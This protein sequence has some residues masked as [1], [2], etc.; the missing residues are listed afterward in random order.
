MACAETILCGQV[1]G[2]TL[3]ADEAERW[4][5]H[6]LQCPHCSEALRTAAEA[7]VGLDLGG[8]PSSTRAGQR[9]LARRLHG[10]SVRPARR[11]TA[12]L[13]IAAAIA[14]AAGIFI[15]NSSRVQA[16]RAERLI[17]SA[18]GQH[19][20]LAV[21]LAGASYA[22]LAGVLR[23]EVGENA[24]G[25]AEL[26]EA[27]A[28]AAAGLATEPANADWLRAQAEADLLEGRSDAAVAALQRALLARP[29]D[30]A[31]LTDLGAAYYQSG[32][33]GPTTRYGAALDA[34]GQALAARAHDPL[35]RY[36]RALVEEA[37]EDWTGAIADWSAFLATDGGSDWAAEARQHLDTDRQ[38]VAHHDAAVAAPLLSPA[39]F[40]GL[41]PLRGDE[42]GRIEEYLHQAITAWLP[43]AYP[44]HGRP[45]TQ[46]QAGLRA[47]AAWDAHAHHDAWLE[48]VLAEARP[49]PA[50]A[51]GAAALAAAVQANAAGTPD[52]ARAAAAVA[53]ASFSAARAPA[54]ARRAGYEEIY[55]LHRAEQGTACL[56]AL[57]QWLPPAATAAEGWLAG[58]AALERTL[59]IGMVQGRDSPALVARALARARSDH[60]P[61]LELRAES[62][63][64][65]AVANSGSEQLW[66]S[67]LAQLNIYWSSP[68]EAYRG[69]EVEMALALAA[70]DQ[71]QWFAAERL[72]SA[73]IERLTHT[74][75]R[76]FEAMARQREADFDDA[77]GLKQE[78]ALERDHADALFAAL[79]STPATENLRALNQ[80][81]AAVGALRADAL[82]AAAVH[83]AAFR[84]EQPEVTSLA[85]RALP[86]FSVQAALDLKRGRLALA[87]REASAAVAIS[88][89]NLGTLASDEERLGWQERERDAYRVLVAAELEQHPDGRAALETWEWSRAGAVRSAAP[90]PPGLEA[91]A[92]RLDAGKVATLVL[93]DRVQMARAQLRDEQ[94]VSY[95]ILPT[96]VAAWLFDDRGVHAA[97]VPVAAGQLEAA[98][99]AFALACA[100]PASD[101]G[102]LRAHGEQLE[103]W[104]L[105]PMARWLDP[106]RTLVVEA[107]GA[108]GEVPFAALRSSD[109]A[110]LQ[111][112][113]LQ[114]PGLEFAAARPPARL[115]RA[116]VLAVGDPAL[117]PALGLPPLP[118]AG[119]EAA[120]LAAGAGARALLG[121]AATREAVLRDLPEAEVFHFAGHAEGG[122]LLLAGDDAL[123]S[124]DLNRG[125]LAHCQLAVLAA[126]STA[127][128]SAGLF[129]AHSFVRACLRS[130]VP[131]V[132]ATRWPVESG[133]A[134]AWSEAFYAALRAG[135][136]VGRA[137]QTAQSA[138][139][140]QPDTAAP[141]YWAAY[142]AFGAPD[143]DVKQ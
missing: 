118:E 121:A 42:D 104:L 92:R 64:L 26:L 11:W 16:W 112:A 31:L 51:H 58:E 37:L 88:E 59:C 101:A 41:R 106:K 47:L 35:A 72:G 20:T 90:L 1:V 108:L 21:R 128:A 105:G 45:D 80:L 142:A 123:S 29:K 12:W 22:P 66:Q 68:I 102:L 130:G 115:K 124:A 24:P 100:N 139:R 125:A 127:A 5:Q 63:A 89:S 95:A 52:A 109:G 73:A 48:Q 126:C 27:E 87:E 140:S 40:A 110:Y 81:D 50:F 85:A 117:D 19:R 129:D 57:D 54:A 74:P 56:A 43:A 99:H 34:L 25:R 61:T 138:L 38:R 46:A 143:E 114:S 7:Q 39:A 135:T 116:P 69:F 36:N 91:A 70:A 75:E 96:G 71:Q 97:Q 131:R 53:E 82:P 93:P 137:L 133:S 6:A 83:L 28:L 15:W 94:V 113:V 62:F 3:A 120:R 49:T 84:R 76:S 17:A 132:V 122:R 33:A 86:F 134:A 77:A 67:E 103:A 18:Y 111:Q 4:L 14:L 119:A 136:P 60:Y 30:P 141:F 10:L 13:G 9:G 32:L 107:D 78:A 65:S 44:A 79:P 2:G 23:G 55:A 8:L 98:A